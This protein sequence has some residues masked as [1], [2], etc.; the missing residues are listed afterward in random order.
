MATTVDVNFMTASHKGSSGLSTAFPDVCKTPAPPAPPVPIPYPN[1]AKS[2]DLSK[3]SKKVKFDGKSVVLKSSKISTSTG[4]EAGTLK[5]LI[6]NKTKG[7]AQFQAYS[8]DVKVEGKNVCRLSDPTMQNMGSPANGAAFFH[9]QAPP[10]GPGGEE[11]LIKDACDNV[12]KSVEKQKDDS[13]GTKFGKSGIITEHQ[14]PIQAA[15]NKLKKYT[16]YFRATNTL[17]GKWIRKKH[18]PKPHSCTAGKTISSPDH[19]N[20][21]QKWL[22]G[23]NRRR[24]EWTLSGGKAAGLTGV[25]RLTTEDDNLGRPRL[26]KGQKY[27]GKWTTGDY[28]LMDILKVGQKCKRPSKWAFGIIRRELNKRMKWDGIQHP[29]QSM[30]NTKEDHA[31]KPNEAEKIE[32]FNVAD[33]L[34]DWSNKTREK[35]TTE[36]IPSQKIAPGRDPLSMVD[37]NLAVVAPKTSVHL[38][39]HGDYWDALA[40]CGC[41]TDEQ[42]AKTASK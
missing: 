4:D 5:G 28:D 42:E 10:K 35:A 3:G 30:W 17:C 39:G 20:S 8:F 21:C 9:M 34:N 37:N 6:S 33:I 7:K 14:S 16:L 24:K 32:H 26:G 2:S 31:F 12:K 23:A 18:Q 41:R 36:P 15:V 22:N 1:I 38:D 13:P 29:P 27:A 11:K 40:C 25:V 19:I